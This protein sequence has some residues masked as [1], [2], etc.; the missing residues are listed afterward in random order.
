MMRKLTPAIAALAFA[1][2]GSA[3]PLSAQETV[4]LGIVSFL[5]GPAAGP[6][7]V[8]GKNAADVVI[9][10]IND[11]SIP[12]PYASKGL[13]GATIEPVFVDEA[14]SAATQVTEYRNL[15][16]RSGVDAVVGY[17]SSGSCLA[18]APVA[19][20][21]KTLTLL[22]DCGTPRIFEE[23]KY[24]YV[25]RVTA[26]ATQDNVAAARYVLDKIPGL[27]SY[28]GINQNYAWG[29]DSWRDFTLAM[30]ALK[31]DATVDRDLMPKLFAGEY[32]AEITTLLTSGSKI[33]HTSLW[34]GD[35]ESFVLQA[36]ARALPTR[37]T[38]VMTAGEAAMFRL[39]SKIPDGTIIGAR[40]EHGVF[41]PDSP[42]NSWFR[43]AYEAKFNAEPTYP[44]YHMAQ[45]LLGLKYAWDK[46]AA[47]NGGKRPTKEQVA[48][49]L[50]GAEF[51]GPSGTI[52]MTL[53]N[54][55]QG[56]SDMAYGTYKFDTKTNKPEIVDIV[57]YPAECVNP[58]P[59]QTAV[60]WI[61]AG[62]PGAKC[63]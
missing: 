13:G 2:M 20:E 55:H 4:K 8:P 56:I 40:G 61:K 5:T 30:K 46:A 57:R 23:A 44:S 18:V 1:L 60:E 16:Q 58:P 62:M 15:V 48:A 42:L 3:Q 45:S 32:G 29:Q 22:Y 31:P 41:A 26:H 47:A 36:D 27:A 25:F 28:S 50:K 24:D 19:E 52:R 14:G 63:K 51:Q 49:A 35:L 17:I 37:S 39:G 38:L 34:G 10:G 54:G 43:K 33:T 9:A 6:F 7:G 21:L 11:G 53:G 59:G 12:A